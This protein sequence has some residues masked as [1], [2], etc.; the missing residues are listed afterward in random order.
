MTGFETLST[1][2]LHMFKTEN[3]I[4]AINKYGADVGGF[5]IGAVF[6]LLF[7]RKVSAQ[8]VR[9]TQLSGSVARNT[10][11]NFIVVEII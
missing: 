3:Q 1:I 7:N 10:F 11:S 2:Y 9:S 5:Y 4:N 6:R 8:Q